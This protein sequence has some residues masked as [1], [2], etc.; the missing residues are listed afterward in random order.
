M[1]NLSTQEV[2]WSIEKAPLVNLDGKI[3]Q[4]YENFFGENF[5]LQVLEESDYV[6]VTGQEHLNRVSLAQQNE[7]MKKIRIFFMN[8]KITEALGKKFGMDL[9]FDSADYWVDGEGY[10]SEPHRDNHII[11][12]HVQIYLSDDNQGTCLYDEEE[13]KLHT[14]EF[15]RN[16]GYALVNNDKSLH[17][18]PRLSKNGRKSLYVRYS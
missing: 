12:L 1:F 9:K 14:F 8:S 3:F 15:K 5:N 16:F 17:G 2:V 7:E 10:V 18:V 4:Q 11:K 13:N 6:K